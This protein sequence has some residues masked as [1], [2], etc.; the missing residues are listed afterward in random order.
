MLYLRIPIFHS[1]ELLLLKS[2][3]DHLHP[4]AESH[5]VAGSPTLRLDDLVALRFQV[6]KKMFY[7]PHQINW[8]ITW[9]V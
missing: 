4:Q 7:N 9:L 6:T 1:P 2:S 8:F 5:P 3:Y